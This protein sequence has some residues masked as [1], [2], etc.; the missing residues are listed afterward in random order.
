MT[1]EDITY[2]VIFFKMLFTLSQLHFFI[3]FAFVYCCYFKFFLHV[4]IR[5]AFNLHHVWRQNSAI[6]TVLP[7]L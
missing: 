6:V 2:F 1:I 7:I 4:G 3:S 5:V